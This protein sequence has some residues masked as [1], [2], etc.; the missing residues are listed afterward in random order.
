MAPLWLIIKMQYYCRF[1]GNFQIHI[2]KMDNGML[3]FSLVYW[4]S[5]HKKNM[6]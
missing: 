6:F 4:I 5:E 2:L 1:R 3:D